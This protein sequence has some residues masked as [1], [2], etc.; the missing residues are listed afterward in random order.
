MNLLKE[1][2]AESF[3]FNAMK[4][5]NYLDQERFGFLDNECFEL[6]MEEVGMDMTEDLQEALMRV[7]DPL[8]T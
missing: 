6:Y 1:D 8:E 4:A 7:I 2:L 3:G 5:F